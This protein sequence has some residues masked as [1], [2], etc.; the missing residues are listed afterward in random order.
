MRYLQFVN[1]KSWVTVSF[2]SFLEIL[3]SHFQE[4]YWLLFKL[5]TPFKLQQLFLF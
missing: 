2:E 5:D 3:L 4:T 1:V